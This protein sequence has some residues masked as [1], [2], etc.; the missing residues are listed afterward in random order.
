MIPAP[1]FSLPQL[2]LMLL[3]FV[4]L[5]LSVGLL[6]HALWWWQST[7]APAVFWSRTVIALTLI[8][9]L[10]DIWGLFLYMKIRQFHQESTLQSHY[11][12]SR[13]QFVLPQDF[14]YGE[15]LIPKGSLINRYDAFDNG[16]P[17]RPLRMNRLDAVR[18]AHPVQ[19]AG[20][21]ASAMSGGVLELDRDQRISSVFHFDD[22][23]QDGYGGW[24][25]DPSRP[26][27]ECKKGQQARFNVPLIDYDI[28][29]EF[30]KP[31]PDG[32]DARFKP[33]QWAVTECFGGRGPIEVKPAYTEAGPEGAQKNVWGPLKNTEAR[34]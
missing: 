33:S 3:P 27:L 31:A 4:T 1:L 30:G 9:V 28:Q 5:A 15:L 14:Q 10:G 11:R 19:V 24:V 32:P 12:Q 13:Q 6:L 20:V 7:N 2:L 8:A 26:Y 22:K 18:F 25:L 17:Q 29:A 34:D 21:W 23:A 16:E